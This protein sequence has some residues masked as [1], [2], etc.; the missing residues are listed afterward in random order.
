[1]IAETGVPAGRQQARPTSSQLGGEF[2]G[3]SG[4]PSATSRTVTPSG[5]HRQR[6]HGRG[7]VGDRRR[8]CAQSVADHRPADGGRRPSPL[9]KAEQIKHRLPGTYRALVTDPLP[10]RDGAVELGVLDQVA[11]VQRLGVEADGAHVVRPSRVGE[12]AQEVRQRHH[13]GLGVLQHGRQADHCLPCHRQSP[14]FVGSM[15]CALAL[16]PR[17]RSFLDAT[18]D[19]HAGRPEFALQSD[20]RER[21]EQP[22]LDSE[23][24]GGR[25]RRGPRL[26]V[27]ALDVGAR[28]LGPDPQRP[29][30]LPG[31]YTLVRS[32][33]APPLHAAPARREP[34]RLATAPRA[35]AAASTAS[36][37]TAASRPA[38]TSR[39]SSWAACGPDSAGRCGRG[40]VI[41]L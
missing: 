41:A 28:R 37:A 39:D 4:T 1:M 16:E 2:H 32:A 25:P 18:D 21:V 14:S 36:T 5:R 33:P 17:R 40:S 34:A 3:F 31:R 20:G 8:W 23:Q 24:R 12:A 30:H 10:H 7:G 9:G 35:A 15:A 38:R 22:V 6:L 26:G 29:G 27:D 11:G 13:H 19:A